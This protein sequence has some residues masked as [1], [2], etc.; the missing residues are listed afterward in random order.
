[1]SKLILRTLVMLLT[2]HLAVAQQA[3]PAEETKEEQETL[4]LSE[5]LVTASRA[6]R[7]ADTVPANVTVITREEILSSNAKN[8]TDVLQQLAGL[9]VRNLFGDSSVSASVDIGGFGEA[10]IYNLVLLIDGVRAGFGDLLPIDWSATP[11]NQ[12]ERI[13]IVRGGGTVLYGA[14]ATGGVINII[15]RAG[16]QN[17][18]NVTGEVD[19]YGYRQAAGISGQHEALGFSLNQGYID[20]DGYRD[21]NHYRS[22]NGHLALSF[23]PEDSW[24]DLQLRA[25]ANDE[26]FGMPGDLLRADLESALVDRRDTDSPSDRGERLSSYVTI[27]P[28]LHFNDKL[29]LELPATYRERDVEFVWGGWEQAYRDIK[30]GVSPQIV[31]E[32]QLFGRDNTFIIGGDYYNTQKH[33]MGNAIETTYKTY[34]LFFNNSLEVIDDVYVDFGYRHGW[35]DYAFEGSEGRS[36]SLDAFRLGLAW[37]Y[38]PDSKLFALYDRSYRQGVVDEYYSVWSGLNTNLDPQITKT[39]QVGIQHLFCPHLLGAVTFFHVDTSNEIFY[40][41]N[42]GNTNYEETERIGVIVEAKAPITEN[43]DLTINYTFTDA[44]MGESSTG[45][46]FDGRQVPLVPRH[47][48]KG[49]M[50]YRFL[51]GFAYNLSARWVDS[52]FAGSDWNNEADELDDFLVVDT[53]LAYTWKWLTVYGGINNLLEEEYTESGFYSSWSGNVGVY[54]MPE[55]NFF[56]GVDLTFNF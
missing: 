11:L 24:Y 53:R 43:L 10:G 32:Y 35:A 30:W 28:I 41:P 27:A 40:D 1:M 6:K 29:R 14:N 7:R 51:D 42:F 4:R 20:S 45:T 23:V 26:A 46:N 50:E 36:F 13:E 49:G 38:Q 3:P 48:V 8:V 37:N 21:N 19:S 39:T 34:A 2:L 12:I 54:P 15:T 18:I 33:N 9:S 25:G 44:E 22:K 56:A 31:S 52:R 5:V 47:M 55:R 17:Q 16:G